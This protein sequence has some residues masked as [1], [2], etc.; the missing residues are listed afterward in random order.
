MPSNISTHDFNSST[1]ECRFTCNP[2]YTYDLGSN[3]CVWNSCMTPTSGVHNGLTYTLTS[4]S[5]AHGASATVTS[6]NRAFGTSP[7]NGATSARFTYS[8]NAWALSLTSTANNAG[9]CI[10]SWYTFNNNYS[11]PACTSPCNWKYHAVFGPV[12]TVTPN[13]NTTQCTY[14][15]NWTIAWEAPP[16]NQKVAT[17][18]CN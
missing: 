17:C 12:W 14:A 4:Q 1:S 8:C 6:A 16:G 11:S 10:T 7:A 5:V 15:N 9:S 18:T 3:T 13:P 2:W